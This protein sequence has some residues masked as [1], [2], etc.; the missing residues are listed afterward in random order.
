MSRNAHSAV[1]SIRGGGAN[2]RECL[3]LRWKGVEPEVLDQQQSEGLDGQRYPIP[4]E[5][6][7]SHRNL[8]ALS[9]MRR[10]TSTAIL[11]KIGHLYTLC[12]WKHIIILYASLVK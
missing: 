7:N 11:Y 1:K 4:T 5:T 2:N 10:H 8:E 12:N 6:G 3:C 9:R